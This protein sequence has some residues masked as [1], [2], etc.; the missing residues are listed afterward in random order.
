MS[1]GRF[2]TFD[3]GSEL[4]YFLMINSSTT[5]EIRLEE[6]VVEAVSLDDYVSWVSNKLD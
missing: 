1:F 3:A 2:T 4:S 6:A 5:N